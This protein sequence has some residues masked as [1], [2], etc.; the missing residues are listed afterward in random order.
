MLYA[1]EVTAGRVSTEL[2]SEH[3]QDKPVF[4]FSAPVEVEIRSD[5]PPDHRALQLWLMQAA[6]LYVDYRQCGNGPTKDGVVLLSIDWT[7][8]REVGE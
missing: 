7:Q 2:L 4:R 8:L 6:R 1:D 3:A 5:Q